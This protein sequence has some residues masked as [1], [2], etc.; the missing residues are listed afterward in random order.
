MA[1]VDEQIIGSPYLDADH[2]SQAAMDYSTQ[3]K[4]LANDQRYNHELGKS[5]A[6]AY[7]EKAIS[8]HRRAKNAIQ[9]ARDVAKT[10][11]EVDKEKEYLQKFVAHKNI[12]DE[13]EAMISTDRPFDR[14]CE[15]IGGVPGGFAVTY[16]LKLLVERIRTELHR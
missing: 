12:Q 14:G 4:H 3:N 11:G 15:S 8:L 1:R 6:Q 9:A 7:H 16:E 2:L 13:H 5:K 10:S